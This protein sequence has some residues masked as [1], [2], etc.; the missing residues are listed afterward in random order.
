MCAYVCVCTIRV[1]FIYIYRTMCRTSTHDIGW[2]SFT[3][4]N[5][6]RESIR[7]HSKACV[8]ERD[9]CYN[10]CYRVLSF[11][12]SFIFHHVLFV[13]NVYKRARTHKFSHSVCMGVYH[14][15]FAE[16]LDKI[17]TLDNLYL[18]SFSHLILYL[19]LTRFNID[20]T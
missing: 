13:F 14:L 19:F 3:Y 9:S 12:L 7:A 2:K 5:K 17:M 10:G 11:F 1:P 4:N 15:L 6:Y 8:N 18:P 16:Y 20:D